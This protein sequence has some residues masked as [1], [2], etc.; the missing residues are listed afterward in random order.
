MGNMGTG[1][2]TR[3]L[4]PDLIKGIAIVL[5][6]YGHLTMVGSCAGVQNCVKGWIYSFHMP[7]FLLISGMFFSSQ[8]ELAAKL[9]KLFFR[10]VVPYVVFISFYLIGL[11]L[12]QNLGIPTSNAPPE[13]VIGFVKTVLFYPRGGYWFLHSLILIQ[14]ALLLGRGWAGTK[15]PASIV[16]LTALLM[17]LLTA[18]ELVRVRTVVYFLIGMVIRSVAGREL[19]IPLLLAVAAIAVVWALDYFLQLK[20]IDQFS[21]MEVVWC[22]SIM[23]VLWSFAERFVGGRGIQFVAWVGRNSLSVLVFHAIFIVFLKPVAGV[24]I[25]IE[26][27]GWLYSVSV[28]L[29]TTVLCLFSAFF[30]DKIR[31]SRYLFGTPQCYMPLYEDAK[32]A[33]EAKNT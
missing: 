26:P 4:A 19:K 31:L 29:L 16:L 11:K 27:S 24:F 15:G 18:F 8:G 33:S 2:K 21:L 17:L 1:I 6:V 20:G 23:M 9:N 30:L 22:L 5:M 12:I 28:T 32:G 7:L 3:Q 25:R 10:I 13:S 14:L